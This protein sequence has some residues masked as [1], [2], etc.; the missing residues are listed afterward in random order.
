VLE[1]FLGVY[2]L[3]KANL[4]DARNILSR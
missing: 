3:H 4:P 1:R 2:F